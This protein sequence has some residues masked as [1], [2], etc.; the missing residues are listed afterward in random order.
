[1][2]RRTQTLSTISW[3]ANDSALIWQL[4]N[5]LAKKENH[6][7]LYGIKKGQVSNL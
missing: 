7:A 3:A 2:A 5:L 4:L 1:M 6:V